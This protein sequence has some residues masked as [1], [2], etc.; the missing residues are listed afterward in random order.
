MLAVKG[1]KI[2]KAGIYVDINFMLNCWAFSFFNDAA[3]P[4]PFSLR[5]QPLPPFLSLS[6]CCIWRGGYAR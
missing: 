5:A 4:F 6:S 3:T 1:E 2:L